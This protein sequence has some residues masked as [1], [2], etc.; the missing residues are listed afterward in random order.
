MIRNLS[1]N[2]EDHL[3]LIG[4][5]VRKPNYQVLGIVEDVVSE[6]HQHFSDTCDLVMR[7]GQRVNINKILSVGVEI[8]LDTF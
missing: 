7:D 2:R 8:Q 5:Q 4:M 3:S 1:M 6:M